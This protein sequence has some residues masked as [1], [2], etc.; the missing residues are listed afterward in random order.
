MAVLSKEEFFNRLNARVGDSQ[1]D[2]DIA[3]MEDMTD[4]YSSLEKQA[5]GD[6]VDWEKKFKEN[7]ASWRKKYTARFF[8]SGGGTPYT[9]QEAEEEKRPEDVTFNDIFVRKEG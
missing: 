6:G 2:E 9:E 4:T 8:S 3:F 1:S 7:D 5:Q